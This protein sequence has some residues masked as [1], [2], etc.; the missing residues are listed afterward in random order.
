MEISSDTKKIV[1]H[2]FLTRA[3]FNN[4]AES[5]ESKQLKENQ[6]IEELLS[7][8]DLK[9][10]ETILDIGC[11]TGVLFPFFE[12]LTH[13]KSKIFAIDFA[14]S[15]VQTA[16]LNCN[17]NIGV[18]CGDSQSLPFK[19]DY[20]DRI[21]A[22]HVFPHLKKK[23]I[24]LQEYWQVLKPEGELAIIH[25]RGSDELNNFHAEL[26]GTVADH[27]LPSASELSQTLSEIGYDVRNSID[28]SGE[29]FVRAIKPRTT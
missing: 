12:K 26:G 2:D 29:Y 11:G 18:I 7:R 4:L 27:S 28:A 17:G 14:E 25:L 6:K 24:A 3:Y 22:F 15:M 23:K 16:V 13:R 9:N 21:V 20:F 1:N 19:K 8:L 5:W 10:A